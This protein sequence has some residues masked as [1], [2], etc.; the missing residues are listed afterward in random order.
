[1]KFKQ[2][3][4]SSSEARGGCLDEGLK[5]FTFGLLGIS[6]KKIGLTWTV[7]EVSKN[8]DAFMLLEVPGV[9]GIEGDG[10]VGSKIYWAPKVKRSIVINVG[11]KHSK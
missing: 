8:E 2:E 5:F 1:M 9:N 3:H 11:K 4:E 6:S 7:T 10:G